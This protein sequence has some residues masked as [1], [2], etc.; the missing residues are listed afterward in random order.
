MPGSFKLN[1]LQP[2]EPLFLKKFFNFSNFILGSP[3]LLPQAV[4]KRGGTALLKLDK[5]E[6][7]GC[8]EHSNGTALITYPTPKLKETKIAFL[9]SCVNS[10]KSLRSMPFPLLVLVESSMRKTKL[11]PEHK[12]LNNH[13]NIIL[14]RFND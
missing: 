4:P 2:F 11:E 13:H 5:A 1:N 10:G 7:T 12:H 8:L 9:R 3:I 6:G 14:E